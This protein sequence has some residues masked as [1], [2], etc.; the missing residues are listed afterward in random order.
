MII[1]LALIICFTLIAIY[2]LNYYVNL[3]IKASVELSHFVAFVIMLILIGLAFLLILER[4]L[5]NYG[6][7]LVFVIYYLTSMLTRGLVNK[8][9]VEKS[10]IFAIARLNKWTDIQEMKFEYNKDGKIDLIFV[11]KCRVIRQ[12]YD[13]RYEGNFIKIK[14]KLK[15]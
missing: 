15:I 9:V 5:A 2:N 12:R 1:R 4:N 7:A 13:D 8:G 3:K 14:K 10:F 11:T 6:L